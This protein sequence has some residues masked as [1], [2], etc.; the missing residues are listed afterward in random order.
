M[1]TLVSLFLLS[2]CYLL[3]IDA[4]ESEVFPTKNAYWE[5]TSGHIDYV[6][7]QYKVTCYGNRTDSF[8][9]GDTVVNGVTTYNKLY[10]STLLEER[11][12]YGYHYYMSDSVLYAGLRVDNKKV[13]LSFNFKDEIL[14]YDFGATKGDTIYLGKFRSESHRDYDA[15]HYAIIDSVAIGNYGKEI[16]VSYIIDLKD[17]I[18]YSW[19]RDCSDVW[20]EGIGSTR[21]LFRLFWATTTNGD[22]DGSLLRRCFVNDVLKYPAQD[23]GPYLAIEEVKEAEKGSLL[24]DR[25]QKSLSISLEATAGSCQLEVYNLQGVTVFSKEVSESGTILLNS[26]APGFYLCTIK[27]GNNILATTKIER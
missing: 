12:P 8:I 1:K 15:D 14:L 11:V 17:D 20:I 23:P 4:Q 16:H 24:Y 21:G 9:K 25:S 3:S 19:D 7:S 26:L 2:F 13:Y 10:S 18:F 22:T 5:I 6:D 27:S